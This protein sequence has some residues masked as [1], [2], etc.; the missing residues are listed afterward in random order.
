M[1]MYL[2]PET[3]FGTKFESYLN[4]NIKT[5]N[6]SVS[7]KTRF[8]VENNRTDNYSNDELESVM[9]RKRREA[10]ERMKGGR[11]DGG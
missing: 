4:E 1:E 6:K 8:H 11:K 5:T 9:E 2:R 10:R 7:K 3:L